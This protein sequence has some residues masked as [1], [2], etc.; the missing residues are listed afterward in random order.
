MPRCALGTPPANDEECGSQP[1]DE[2]L[3]MGLKADDEGDGERDQPGDDSMIA[4]V[5]IEILKGIINP[6]IDDQPP[7]APKSGNKRGLTH[8]D[9]SSS[10]SDSS[11]E[12]LDAKGIQSKKKGVTP[13]KVTSNPSQWTEEDIDIVCQIR[14]KT[15][16]DCFQTYQ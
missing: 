12:D 10:S 13:T 11:D 9:G 7:T 14:Y 5:E 6:G 4:L 2:D 3:D 8:L 16:L 15:D 1:L